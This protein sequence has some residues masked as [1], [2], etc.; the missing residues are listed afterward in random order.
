V[1]QRVDNVG[2]AVRELELSLRFYTALGFE[3]ES[4]DETPAATLKAGEARLWVFQTT[5]GRGPQRTLDLTTNPTGNDHVS[6]WV[7]DVD[8]AAEQARDAGLVLESE[9]ADQEWGY[10]ATS[11]LD[12]DGNRIFLLGDLRV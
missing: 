12:P 9:P 7:G 3:I 5:A 8:S 1:I 6:F 10:R 2:V 11:L 4:R